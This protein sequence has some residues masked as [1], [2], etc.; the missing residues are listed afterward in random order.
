MRTIYL[1][2]FDPVTRKSTSVSER[3][4]FGSF[5]EAVAMMGEPATRR[6]AFLIY[7]GVLLSYVAFYLGERA[8]CL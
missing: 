8:E 2:P 3:S 1:T 7:E 6:E 5:D 4:G